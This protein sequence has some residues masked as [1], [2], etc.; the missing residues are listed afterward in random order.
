MKEQPKTSNTDELSEIKVLLAGTTYAPEYLKIKNQLS[1]NQLPSASKRD[2][3]LEAMM[4]TYI[5]TLGEEIEELKSNLKRLKTFEQ[6]LVKK[7][8]PHFWS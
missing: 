8:C 4:T 5:P 3:T 1:N 2:A 7:Q 6:T